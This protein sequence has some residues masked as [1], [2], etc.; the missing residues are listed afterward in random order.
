MFRFTFLFITVLSSLIAFSQ[1][2]Q[3]GQEI[4]TELSTFYYW[5]DQNDGFGIVYDELSFTPNF[6]VN[7]A[8][9]IYVGLR[10]YIIRGR[11]QISPTFKGWHFLIGPNLKYKLYQKQRFEFS[12]ELGYYFGNY[13]PNCFPN[14]VYYND[15]LQ[16]IG[17]DIQL[18]FLV[19][20][21]IPEFW[22]KFSFTTNSVVNRKGLNG[23]NLPLFGLQYRFGK[24]T[25]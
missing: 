8:D 25:R 1:Q 4:E 18:F 2:K 23:Y 11:S 7:I 17:L 12:A 24:I 5:D 15:N 10:S 3:I 6:S 20:K 16:Y 13:C 22:F 9:K 19:F 21:S 14:N